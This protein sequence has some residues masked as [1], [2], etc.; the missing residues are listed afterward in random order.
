[1][2]KQVMA[3]LRAAGVDGIDEDVLADDLGID[4][5]EGAGLTDLLRDLRAEG[6]VE[7]VGCSWI[8]ISLDTWGKDIARALGIDDAAERVA[9]TL[10]GWRQPGKIVR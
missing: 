9:A 3:Q 10:R 2:R 5:P 7:G 6:V 4:D 1:M 8:R